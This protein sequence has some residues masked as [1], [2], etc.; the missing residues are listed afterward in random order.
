MLILFGG[1]FDPIHLGHI[2]LANT[3]H[4]KFQHPVTFMPTGL[5]SYKQL[6]IATITQRLEMLN[7][8]I[9][10]NKSFNI[11]TSEML[12]KEPCN[13]YKTLFTIRKKIGKNIPIF[14]LI[15][16]D[17]LVTLDSW[18]NWQDLLKLTNFIVATRSGFNLDTMETKLAYEFNLRKTTVLDKDI[19]NGMFYLMDFLPIDISSTQIRANIKNHKSITNLVPKTVEQ[20]ILTKGIYL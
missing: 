8:A 2:S 17:S 7:L 5:Q 12:S 11:D 13:T 4:D 15:G 3:L 18:D 14:F 9:A 19:I 20:Y 10:N 16:H 1:T 6:P